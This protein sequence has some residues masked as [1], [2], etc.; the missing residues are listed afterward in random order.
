MSGLAWGDV[1]SWVST[2]LALIVALRAEMTSRRAR[3]LT[4]DQSKSQE[5]IAAATEAMARS[6]EA[7]SA[8]AVPTMPDGSEPNRWLVART[9][10]N[11][12]TLRNLGPG[13]VHGVE[14]DKDRLGGARVDVRGSSDLGAMESLEIM[15]VPSFGHPVANE[16]WVRSRQHPQ[17][18]AVPMPP[19]W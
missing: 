2:G 19:P 13:A 15:T 4:R 6:A 14:V 16:V 7:P 17:W 3:D 9:G 1:A 5:R 8:S 10:K 11:L 18:E 12:V